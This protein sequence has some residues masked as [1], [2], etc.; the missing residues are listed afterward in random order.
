M[1]TI[2]HALKDFLNG[3]VR[4][5][6]VFWLYFAIPIT[7]FLA[8]LVLEIMFILDY[9]DGEIFF[10][11]DNLLIV[12][13]SVL[14]LITIFTYLYLPLVYVAMW[15]S[16]TNYTKNFIYPFL[17]KAIVILGLVSIVKSI[18]EDI[19]DLVSPYPNYMIL[20][21]YRLEK[22]MNKELP[23]VTDDQELTKVSF[24]HGAF[25]HHFRILPIP[26]FPNTDTL[27]IDELMTHLKPA[28]LE[29]FCSNSYRAILANGFNVA[30]RY[31][32]GDQIG[33]IVFYPNDCESNQNAIDN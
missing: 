4:L 18:S 23:M 32:V 31:E 16:A 30:F 29:K 22:V 13:N 5:A 6:I 28:L 33:E 7:I 8:L 12:N 21:M 9:L 19:L 3:K 24:E 2:I 27:D 14:T 25:I 20:D 10:L 15:N 11:L 17:V 1:K 26:T